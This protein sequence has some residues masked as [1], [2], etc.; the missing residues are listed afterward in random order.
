MRDKD[1]GDLGCSARACRIQCSTVQYSTVHAHI[2]EHLPEDASRNV[3]YRIPRRPYHRAG[4]TSLVSPKTACVLELHAYIRAPTSTL[5]WTWVGLDALRPTRA[6]QGQACRL[7]LLLMAGGLSRRTEG[8]LA[9]LSAHTARHSAPRLP[10]AAYAARHR[11]ATLWPLLN[12]FALLARAARRPRR[13]HRDTVLTAQLVT[14][15]AACSHVRS[16]ATFAEHRTNR[17]D[18]AQLSCCPRNP[19]ERTRPRSAVA[20]R[21]TLAIGAQPL[22]RVMVMSSKSPGEPYH[23][24]VIHAHHTRHLGTRFHS[25]RGQDLSCFA[26]LWVSVHPLPS[27]RCASYTVVNRHG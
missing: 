18:H 7:Q 14:P 13:F 27:H 23:C 3:E 8:G 4:P 15:G 20:P 16:S 24:R 22:A 6:G 17:S 9:A 21:A 25:R 11:P 2:L 19:C 10:F 1:L 26:G 12:L 5:P